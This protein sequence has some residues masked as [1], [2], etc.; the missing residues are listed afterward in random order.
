MADIQSDARELLA[1]VDIGSNSVR[2][3]IYDINTE[4]GDFSVV[5]SSRAM[6]KL[7]SYVSNGN[8]NADGEGK[9]FA[10]MREYLA[11]SNGMLCDKFTA[12]ATASLRGLSNASDVVDRIKNRL[13]VEINIISGEDEARY[14]YAATVDR[15]GKSM[16]RRGIV[17]DMGGGST[18][19]IA[20]D[21][22]RVRHSFSLPIGSLGLWKRFC[23][24]RKD[25]PFPTGKEVAEIE[26]YVL[27]EMKK[28]APLLSFGGTAYIIGGTARAVCRIDA[29][30]DG[31]DEKL[32]GYTMPNAKFGR[33][34]SALIDDASSGAKLISRICPDRMTSIVTGAVA[35][36]KIIA[37]TGV[38][39][40]ILSQAGVREG[41]V[42]EYIRKTYPKTVRE[43]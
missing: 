9:L 4:T 25:D 30:L 14:D 2:M 33:V 36:E 28:A 23:G 41:F 39:R 35:Y 29:S 21:D 11:K 43:F 15:F 13:G 26:K 24:A 31:A 7:I 1:V 19:L 16:S 42:L 12:F 6:L 10:L 37:A 34:K 40:A 8:L 27:E 5:S 17:I 18:E 22:R 3:N 20:F 38:S 32:D